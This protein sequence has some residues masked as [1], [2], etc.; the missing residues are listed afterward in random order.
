MNDLKVFVGNLPF[1]AS[2]DDIHTLF[3][4]YGDIQGINI[5]RDAKNNSRG[6]AFVT[7]MSP[8][9]AAS[10]IVGLNGFT[11]SGR[12]LTVNTASLRGDSSAAEAA[13]IDEDWK[14]VPTPRNTN[15]SDYK[16]ND[17]KKNKPQR[18]TWDQ[19]A[20]PVSKETKIVDQN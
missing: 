17:M 8:D 2:A 7:Y 12:V 4:P 9:E 10:A 19:W 6:F 16:K 20:G 11:Y 3:S 15:N 1:K 13:A 5:R 18:R 14:T